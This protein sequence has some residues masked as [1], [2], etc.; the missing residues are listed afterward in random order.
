MESGEKGKELKKEKKVSDIT[1]WNR[2]IVDKFKKPGRSMLQTSVEMINSRLKPEGSIKLTIPLEK[3]KGIAAHSILEKC[4]EDAKRSGFEFRNLKEITLGSEDVSYNIITY[5][6]ERKKMSE[7]NWREKRCVHG[8]G[9]LE[10][11]LSC[12]D[13]IAKRLMGEL[14]LDNVSSEAEKRMELEKNIDHPGYYN[15]G[16]IEVIDFI[17]DQRLGFHLGNVVKYVCRE[18]KARNK[19]ERWQDLLKARWYLDRYMEKVLFSDR[20]EC[21]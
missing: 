13:E 12:N 17:E 15:L 16:R 1:D 21:E 3:S 8:L 5:T 6:A 18:G 20:E 2:S 14:G 4:K 11:C 10:T 7:E 19:V 9:Y